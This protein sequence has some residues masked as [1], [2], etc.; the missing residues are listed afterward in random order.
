MTSAFRRKIVGRGVP[1]K[2]VPRCCI[3]WSS[4]SFN[5]TSATYNADHFA[6]LVK[7]KTQPV[8]IVISPL[9]APAENPRPVKACPPSAWHNATTT[10]Q[11]TPTPAYIDPEDWPTPAPSTPP[12]PPHQ[13]YRRV[14]HT[15][16]PMFGPLRLLHICLHRV[17][18]AHRSQ[19]HLDNLIS[20]PRNGPPRLR[21]RPRL[22]LHK[23]TPTIRRHQKS[24]GPLYPLR[25]RTQ[26]VYIS[27]A[28]LRLVICLTAPQHQ[29]HITQGKCRHPRTRH[30][31][32]Q[33]TPRIYTDRLLIQ[34]IPHPLTLPYRSR[35]RKRNIIECS[36]NSKQG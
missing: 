9:K 8:S 36:R 35:R 19:N 18:L 30:P 29:V 28:P 14:Q 22:H 21:R 5:P 1:E 3:M 12:P 33:L 32:S 7:K 25:L 10:A 31:L 27:V 4:S 20:I 24:P 23:Q 13:L 6:F 16:T 11:I 34:S 15:R 17:W 2:K 26:T